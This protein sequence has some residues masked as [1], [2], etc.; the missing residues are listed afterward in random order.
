[1]FTGISLFSCVA[2]LPVVA[3]SHAVCN[4]FVMLNTVAPDISRVFGSVIHQ[5][6]SL[7]LNLG[8]QIQS[9]QLLTVLG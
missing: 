7:D 6:P 5:E 4:T 3:L 8:P 2:R 9:P 1:M